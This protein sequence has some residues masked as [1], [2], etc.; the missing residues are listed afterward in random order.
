[1][2]FNFIQRLFVLERQWANLSTEQRLEQ[3]Q[4]TAQPL[5][6][7]LAQWFQKSLPLIT[8]KSQLG[9]AMICLHKQWGKLTVFLQSGNVPIHNNQAENK[10]RPFVIGRKNWV[11]NDSV[12]GAESSA[13]IYNLIE[14]AEANDLSPDMYLRWLF[15]TL[16]NADT[17]SSKALRALLLYGVDPDMILQSLADKALSD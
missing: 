6:D 5:I 10:I 13:G 17:T 14:T 4:L 16:P 7:G 8:P 15:N 9:R 2:G 12:K 1:M 11:F 3:R